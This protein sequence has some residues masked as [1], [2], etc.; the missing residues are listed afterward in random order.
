[1]RFL[2]NRKE[3]KQF[4]IEKETLEKFDEV[5]LIKEAQ[6]GFIEDVAFNDSLLGQVFGMFG[7]AAKKA[8][9]NKQIKNK[10]G[11]LQ[12][13]FNKV[14]FAKSKDSSIIQK[15]LVYTLIVEYIEYVNRIVGQTDEYFN[16]DEY[17]LDSID[18]KIKDGIDGY[19]E[20]GNSFEEEA[21]ALGLDKVIEEF[22]KK[23]D[24]YSNKLKEWKGMSE[25]ELKG[26]IEEFIN[27]GNFEY[28]K[29]LYKEV[30]GE[31]EEKKE[32]TATPEAEKSNESWVL[33]EG[34]ETKFLKDPKEIEEYEKKRNEF[35]EIGRAHV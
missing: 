11:K 1:M 20:L 18:K 26:E 19:T 29:K 14:L 27:D 4:L 5:N 8:V 17:T 7:R 33:N 10:V 30:A 9:K 34:A 13:E 23:F 2:A 16:K 12:K 31:E 28:L 24:N 3:F 32:M 35:I 15:K 25:E 6:D 22:K 21:K